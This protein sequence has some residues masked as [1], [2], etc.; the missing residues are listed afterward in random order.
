MTVLLLCQLRV[1][2]SVSAKQIQD[3]GFG[4]LNL[5]ADEIAT[6]KVIIADNVNLTLQDAVNN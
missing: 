3:A 4:S 2:L 6:D 5:S 1:V